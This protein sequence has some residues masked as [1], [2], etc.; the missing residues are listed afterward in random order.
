MIYRQSKLSS[1]QMLAR[2]NRHSPQARP[3]SL[4]KRIGV[5]LPFPTVVVA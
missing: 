4:D 3:S 1:C 2:V 5:G